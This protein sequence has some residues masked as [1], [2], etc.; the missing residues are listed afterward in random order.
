MVDALLSLDDDSR[1]RAIDAQ[2]IRLLE[3]VMSG[4]VRDET[5][6]AERDDLPNLISTSYSESEVKII[7]AIVGS[8]IRANAFYN[9][10]L[11]RQAAAEAAESVPVEMRTFARGQMIIREG[12]IATAAHIE[13]LEQFGLLR[14]TRHRT[15]RFFGGL[16][17]MTLVTVLLG[18]YIRKFHPTCCPI[19]RFM[20]VLGA[21]FLLFVAGVQMMDARIMSQPYYFPAAALAFLVATLVGPQFAIV[22]MMALAALAGFMTGNSLE[23][24]ILIGCG[25]TLGVLS[26]GRTE[27]L[28]AYFMAGGVVSL[29][30]VV[31][32]AVVRIG[33]G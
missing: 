6:Q 26:L 21:L 14:E 11:T 9:E 15:E 5:I 18:L 20:V 2:V 8:L 13:A 28:N 4:E 25:G 23:F 24:A 12:E 19:C 7:T 30:G 10:E 3:R 17:A 33:H 29:S 1:W 32:R 27:R 16:L 31:R 22:M